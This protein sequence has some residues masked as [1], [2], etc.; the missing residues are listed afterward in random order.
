M[1]NKYI[2]RLIKEWKSYGKI[3]VGVDFDSTLS[4]YP[5][6]DNSEDIS[7]CISLLK[8]VKSVGAYLV[9]FTCCDEGRY[10]DIYGFCRNNGLS[11]DSINQNPI[12]LPFGNKNKPYCNIYLDDRSGF[13]QSMDILEEATNAMSAQINATNTLLQQF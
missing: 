3:I 11:I 9:V 5:T 7:R 13:T 4:P 8:R 1:E 12:D 2:S 10:D 6:I